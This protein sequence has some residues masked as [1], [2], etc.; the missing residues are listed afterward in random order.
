MH[1]PTTSM[2]TL[3]LHDALPIF[4]GDSLRPE[5]GHEPV[6]VHGTL[7]FPWGDDEVIRHFDRVFRRVDKDSRVLK[8]SLPGGIQASEA[9]T[10]PPRQPRSCL[11]RRAN[12]KGPHPSRGARGRTRFPPQGILGRGLPCEC[13]LSRWPCDSWAIR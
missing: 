10:R 9:S 6:V 5:L 11:R 3:S 13:L 12:R 7:D 1:T 4:G 8:R 2:S